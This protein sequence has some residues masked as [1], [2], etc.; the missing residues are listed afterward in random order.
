MAEEGPPT[1]SLAGT[2]PAS[3]DYGEV[4]SAIDGIGATATALSLFWDDLE[5][6]GAYAADPDWPA[7][8]QAVYPPRGL[9]LHLTFSVIDTVADR[10]PADLQDL[11]WDDPRVIDR[12]GSL[13][14]EVL[15][16]MPGVNL[17]S[18]AVGN[19][20]DGF[21]SGASVDEYARFVIAARDA[22]HAHRPDVPVTVKVTWDGLRSRPEILKLARLGDGLSITWYPMDGEFG[23]LVP[24]AALPE[25]DAMAALADG[26]WDLSEV[27]Y[28][29]GGCGASSEVE[30]ARFLTGMRE[31]AASAPGLR[32]VQIV[33]SHDI[34]AA[35][36]S[37]YA[38]YYGVGDPCF[39]SFLATLGL[40]TARGAPKPAYD[41][42]AV[43]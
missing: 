18:V 1:L 6:G 17:V 22:I 24:D 16:R 2:M 29:S 7:I 39:T 28:A 37:A 27:G 42:L 10:R 5:R 15:S 19:E 25:L 4:L 23:L 31:R 12:F 38:G 9:S 30:Q 43:R 32:L 35:E 21:L 8:A 20:V 14:G 41:A 13:A 33:W 26:P 34:P 3:G 40:V 36:V 11:P